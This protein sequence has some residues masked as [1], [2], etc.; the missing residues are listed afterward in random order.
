ML[1]MLMARV[2]RFGYLVLFSAVLGSGSAYGADD[3]PPARVGTQTVVEQLQVQ[4]DSFSGVVHF[5]RVADVSVEVSG[6]VLEVPFQSGDRVQKGDLLVR[7]D[8]DFAQQDIAITRGQM[9]Q[10]QAQLER[11][12]S[13][14]KRRE[15]LMANDAVSRDAFDEAF[16]SVQALERELETLAEQVKRKELEISKSEIRAPFEGLILDTFVQNGEAVAPLTPIASVAAISHIEARV[17]LA[18]EQLRYQQSGAKIAVKV[19]SLNQDIEGSFFGFAPTVDLRSKNAVA[20]IAIPY[21]DGL[22]QNMAVSVQLPMSETQKMRV[23]SRDAV[24]NFQGGNFV[25]AVKDDTAQLLPI[26]IAARVGENVGVTDESVFAGMQVVIDGNDR[27]QPGQNVE[28]IAE[29]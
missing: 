17:S 9:A 4:T 20:K 24:V 16:Y 3:Q 12:Q 29:Q 11:E 18:Q 1:Q 25:Y 13:V 5:A 23:F 8:T 27:L 10:V 19:E 21:R 2:S 14:L 26:T 7:I 28:V 22:L 15:A 6:V